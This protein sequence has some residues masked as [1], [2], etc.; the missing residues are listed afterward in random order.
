MWQRPCTI[1]EIQ[2]QGDLLVD[3]T[4]GLLIVEG[5]FQITHNIRS[6]DK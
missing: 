6:R 5:T 1:R 4:V 2:Q 3:A